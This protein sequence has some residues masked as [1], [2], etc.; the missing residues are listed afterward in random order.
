[1]QILK[2]RFT[3]SHFISFNV[4]GFIS[5]HRLMCIRHLLHLLDQFICVLQLF[6]LFWFLTFLIHCPVAVKIPLIFPTP[7][8]WTLK[9][10]WALGFLSILRRTNLSKSL[11]KHNLLLTQQWTLC[12]SGKSQL[13]PIS[14]L[15]STFKCKTQMWAFRLHSAS[16]QGNILD[17][18]VSFQLGYFYSARIFI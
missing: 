13:L 1:M 4:P 12:E 2:Y 8:W 18:N 16:S 17:V 11:A 5:E 7:C 3:L 14:I 9:L 15:H 10:L 6:D